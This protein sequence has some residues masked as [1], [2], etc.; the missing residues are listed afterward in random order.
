MTK[1]NLFEEL[2]QGIG[3]INQFRAGK[4]TLKTYRVEEAPR[5]EVTLEII[6][7]TR[8]RLNRGAIPDLHK[9]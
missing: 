8:E 1:R 5:V 7:E 3:E 2:K 9:D 4:L 6:R